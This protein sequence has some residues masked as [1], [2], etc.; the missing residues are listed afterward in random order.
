MNEILRRVR[1]RY[2][3]EILQ[4]KLGEFAKSN[5][6]ALLAHL[7][8]WIWAAYIRQPLASLRPRELRDTFDEAVEAFLVQNQRWQ[9]LRGVI[10]D[11]PALDATL[12]QIEA[13][14]VAGQR[15]RLVPHLQLFAPLRREWDPRIHIEVSRGIDVLAGTLPPDT[16][17]YATDYAIMVLLLHLSAGLGASRLPGRRGGGPRIYLR[18]TPVIVHQ[19]ATQAVYKDPFFNFKKIFLSREQ[20]KYLDRVFGKWITHF[21]SSQIGGFLHGY[22][23]D[24]SRGSAGFVGAHKW[25]V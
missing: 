21:L 16:Q 9:I 15:E 24:R 7:A 4:S 23:R 10:R 14:D 11:S 1:K 8:S 5:D 3:D 2:V 12:D 17:K 20:H 19:Y 22:R 13:L 18:N 6:P 25:F